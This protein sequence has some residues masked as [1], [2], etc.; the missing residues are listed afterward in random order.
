VAVGVITDGA[1][2]ILICRRAAHRQQ[3][4]LWEFPGGKVEPGENARAALDRELAEEV[5][6]RPEQAWPLI[7]V[8]YRYPEQEVLLDVWRITRFTGEAHGRE[9][10]PCQWVTRPALTNFRFPAANRPIIDAVSLPS[11]YLITPPLVDPKHL[12]DGINLGLGLG[13][14]LVQ[15]RTGAL[16]DGALEE[17]ARSLLAPIR[18]A[19]GRLLI[20]RRLDIAR[21]VGADGVHLS[22]WQLRALKGRPLPA[23]RLVAASCHDPDELAQARACGVDF[24]VLSPVCATPSHPG[25]TPLGWRTFADW[26]R[27]VPIPVYAL[28]GVSPADLERAWRA[29]AQGVAG[30]RGFWPVEQLS[31]MD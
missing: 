31:R 16:S 27:D 22:A 2:R 17:L 4:G 7:R 26:I 24:A 23:G 15:L 12:F 18:A 10:Q 30:I 14:R 3:G 29:R 1:S 20:S 5:G 21:R 19:G 6:I 25:H 8:P 28:G 11:R 13:C 9:G